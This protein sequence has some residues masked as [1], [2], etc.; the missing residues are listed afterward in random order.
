MRGFVTTFNLVAATSLCLCNW[1]V[2]LLQHFSALWILC[3]ICEV[4]KHFTTWLYVLL[5]V[6]N[7]TLA[8]AEVAITCLSRALSP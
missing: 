2:L 7:T 5:A 4:G 8:L 3:Y 6:H 1:L